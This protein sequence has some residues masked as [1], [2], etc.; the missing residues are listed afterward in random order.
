MSIIKVNF[1]KKNATC[2][3]RDELQ[4]KAICNNYGEL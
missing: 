2:N 3:N 1:R 4:K